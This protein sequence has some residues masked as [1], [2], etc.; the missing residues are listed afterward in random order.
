VPMWF[1]SPRSS[2]LSSSSSSFAMDP[3]IISCWCFR[4]CGSTLR[5]VRDYHHR[6]QCFL[7]NSELGFSNCQL[8][9]VPNWIFFVPYHFVCKHIL[10][11]VSFFSFV[12]T[13]W[14]R[15][16]WFLDVWVCSWTLWLLD[17]DYMGIWGR[18][19]CLPL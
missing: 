9:F 7:S 12:I 16:W 10:I 2:S 19:H 3:G 18:I 15:N 5:L 11:A 1:A 8:K 14:N 13:F 4:F 6:I 17:W